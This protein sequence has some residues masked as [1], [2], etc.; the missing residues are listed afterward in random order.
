MRRDNLFR[1]VSQGGLGLSHLFVRQLVSRF[2][3]LR[4]QEHPLLRCLV[5][6]ILAHHIPLFLVTSYS[7]GETK[8]VGFLK[9]VADSVSFL[10]A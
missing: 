7:H 5:Q 10:T 3:F 2:M 8:V 9:E 6:T 1:R 4:D